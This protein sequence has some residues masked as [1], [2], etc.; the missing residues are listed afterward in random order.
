[1]TRLIAD[2]S[3]WSDPFDVESRSRRFRRL[4]S[5]LIG[6]FA[7]LACGCSA[8]DTPEVW[9]DG[10][11]GQACGPNDAPVGVI[12][13][14]RKD[15]VSVWLNGP[16]AEVDAGSAPGRSDPGKGSVYLCDAKGCD[17][18]KAADFKVR[19]VGPDAWR[20]DFKGTFMRAGRTQVVHG[21]FIAHRT[22][23]GPAM[24]CG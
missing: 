20:V 19:A 12:S 6:A 18:G 21:S 10:L 22:G 13:S 14:T 5:F 7:L 3:P 11:I 9:P 1:M 2:Q 23:V 15:G 24:P 4:V 17:P 16:D 8:G